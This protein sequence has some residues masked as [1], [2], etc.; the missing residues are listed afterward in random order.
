M[1]IETGMIPS[2]PAEAFDSADDL[3][4][5][6]SA[7]RAQHG[8]IFRARIYGSFVYVVKD[9]DTVTVRKIVTGPADA[10]RTVVSDGLAVG[11]KVV[12]DGAFF[13]CGI[14]SSVN[15]TLG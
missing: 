3:L 12:I 4:V 10:T 5:W 14:F 15:D 1:R 6:M 11:E 9:D 2:G 13:F 8:D 7:N